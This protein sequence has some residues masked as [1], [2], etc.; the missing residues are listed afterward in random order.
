MADEYLHPVDIKDAHVLTRL[1][2]RRAKEDDRYNVPFAP[3][4]PTMQRKV[5]LMVRHFDGS[6]MAPFKADNALTPI[7]KGGGDITELYFEL[8]LIAEKHPLTASDLIA[9][10]SVDDVVA[11]AAARDIV[12]LGKHLRIRNTNR[13][14]WMAWQAMQDNLTVTYPDGATIT[15]DYDLNGDNQNSYFS[16][17]HLPTA[18]TLWSDTTNADIIENVYTWT[19]LIADDAG[20]EQSECILHVNST[21]WRYMKKNAGIKAELSATNPRIITPRM[22]EVT[23]ILEIAKISLYNGYYTDESDVKHKFLPDGKALITG[24][25]TI[26]GDPIIEMLDGPVVRVVGNDLVVAQNPGALSE[27]Y[28]NEEQITKN[29]RVQTARLPMVNYPNAI[30]WATVA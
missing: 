8:F 17:S 6:G 4:T 21:T 28:I 16:G 27:I 23:E 11:K 30:V 15:I 7:A 22:N 10:E 9:L 1:I 25:Y 24:P 3:L 19:K 20:V 12:E 18:A 13:T 5:K 2:E 26:N 14:K 29:I